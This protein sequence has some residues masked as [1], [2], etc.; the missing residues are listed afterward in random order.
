MTTSHPQES[1]WDYP[2]PPRVEPA[3]RHLKVVHDGQVLAETRQAFRVLETSHPPC[4]YLPP[5]SVDWSRL[6]PSDTSTYC[7]FKGRARY[8]NLHTSGGTIRDVCWAYEHPTDSHSDIAGYIS[9]YAGRV[10]AC[11]V[12]GEQV[13]AQQ[14]SFYGGWITAEIQGPFKGGPGTVGW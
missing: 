12:D 3:Q 6:E 8:W 4:Y 9:F 13:Q 14:G 7:E 1:V 11:Y 10:E 5:D 2:R